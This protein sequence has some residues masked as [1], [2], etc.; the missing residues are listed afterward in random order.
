MTALLTLVSLFHINKTFLDDS[1]QYDSTC[2]TD[3]DRSDLIEMN[4]IED[5]MVE[6]LC[7]KGNRLG[8]TGYDVLISRV[9]LMYLVH[10]TPTS[11]NHCPLF[12]IPT[13]QAQFC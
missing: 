7:L 9:Y 11:L 13:I 10:Y 1:Q 4:E 12:R 8:N 6:F 5:F 2:R 3:Q